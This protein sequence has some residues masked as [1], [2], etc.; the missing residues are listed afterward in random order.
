MTTSNNQEP[1]WVCIFLW[2]VFAV[3]LPAMLIEFLWKQGQKK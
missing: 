3:F 1:L 2:V